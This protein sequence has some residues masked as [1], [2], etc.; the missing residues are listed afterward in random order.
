MRRVHIKAFT[1]ADETLNA[2]IAEKDVTEDSE[3]NQ[4]LVYELPTLIK[5][6]LHEGPSRRLDQT[7]FLKRTCE[8]EGNRS[9]NRQGILGKDN[10]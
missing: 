4:K 1:G 8:P 2:N 7:S 3:F 6:S 9:I 5:S 10:C